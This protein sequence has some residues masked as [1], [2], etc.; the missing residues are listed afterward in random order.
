MR[1]Q[2]GLLAIVALAFAAVSA[3]ESRAGVLIITPT[4]IAAL[5]GN[6]T[7]QGDIDAAILITLGSSTERYKAEVGGPETGSASAYYETRFSNTTNDPSDAYI[8]WVGPAAIKALGSFLLVKD[9]NQTP[10]WYLFRLADLGWT[11]NKDLDLQ[12]FWPGNG[13]ISHV[14]LYGT[15]TVTP[16]AGS[17]HPVP[18]PGAMTLWLMVAVGGAFAARRKS[19][20][21][22]C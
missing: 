14:T 15:G 3:A 20:K 8:D 16:P 13:A 18:E 10:A 2:S 9:G 11:E 21:A 5:T 7:K 22:V 19:T 1:F 6:Q 12:D 4:S 17:S